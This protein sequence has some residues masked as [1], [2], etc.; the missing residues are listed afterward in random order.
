MLATR[1]IERG[2]RIIAEPPLFAMDGIRGSDL[3]QFGSSIEQVESAWAEMT[4]DEQTR[5]M[6][7][8]NCFEHDPTRPKYL[9]DP[10]FGRIQT[11][12][13][14]AGETYAVAVFDNISRIN[15]SCR[16]NATYYWNKLLLHGLVFATR[17]IGVGEEILFNYGHAGCT[18]E[19]RQKNLKRRYD[20]T[21]KCD[22]CSLPAAERV[23]SDAQRLEMEQLLHSIQAETNRWSRPAP[24]LRSGLRLI[25]LI[26]IEGTADLRASE[27]YRLMSCR[28][29]FFGDL[30]RGV[31]FHRLF[32]EE[33][34]HDCGAD[35]PDING[36]IEGLHKLETHPKYQA[37]G[38][39]ASSRSSSPKQLHDGSL[40]EWLWNPISVAWCVE[41]T[42][43]PKKQVERKLCRL[44]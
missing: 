40:E 3:G 34:I 17:D 14:E 28:A 30:A 24:E 2:E 33:A 31:S 10:L 44:R 23:K 9:K 21:C 20:F 4:R 7:L 41:P 19:E 25:K 38:L 27:V 36:Q 16:G 26:A 6:A 37:E 15:H 13:W 29:L 11:N 1:A 22:I 18:V 8:T 43:E 5:F 35:S 39:W 12:T 42:N 32:I